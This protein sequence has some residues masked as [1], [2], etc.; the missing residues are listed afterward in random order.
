MGE[1]PSYLS[2]KALDAADSPRPTVTPPID[3]PET[4]VVEELVQGGTPLPDTRRPRVG[5]VVTAFRRRRY[6]ARALRSIARGSERPELIVL[7]EDHPPYSES[8]AGV[9]AEHAPGVP[10][11][12]VN[13]GFPRMGHMMAWAISRCA[14]DVVC[15]LDDDDAFLPGHV[16]RARHLFATKPEVGYLR[17]GTQWVDDDLAPLPMRQRAREIPAGVVPS[18]TAAWLAAGLDT[19]SSSLS[20]RR[21]PYL[22]YLGILGGMPTAPDA[23]MFWIAL[24]AGL[25]CY[26]DPTVETL[27]A[28]QMDFERKDR[29]RYPVSRRSFQHLLDHSRA[30]EL[31]ATYAGF[32]VHRKT[33]E[34]RSPYPWPQDLLLRTVGVLHRG[35]PGLRSPRGRRMLLGLVM[36]T[37]R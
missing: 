33:E 14:T 4:G 10:A 2:T 7:V 21:E 9:I 22:P 16:E 30:G 25:L 3:A 5:V 13:G 24:R 28:C 23:G 26:S 6:L 37:R 34:I 17:T 19:N 36:A 27:R 12:A 32:M 35:L 15:G 20:F 31:E 8:S 11:I 1:V 29:Y 18:D